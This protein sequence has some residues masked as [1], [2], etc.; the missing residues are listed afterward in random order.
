MFSIQQSKQLLVE[1]PDE[2]RLFSAL[3][4]HLNIRD[5]QVVG[6]GGYSGLRPFLRTFI[7]LPSFDMVQSVAIVADA[8]TNRTNREA[9]VHDAIA[10]VS[11]PTPSGP[12]QIASSSNIRVVYL[13]VPSSHP[14][15]MIEDVCLDS[16]DGDPALACVNDYF[17]CIEQSGLPGPKQ[18]WMSK[19]RVHAFLASRE[20][21]RLRLGEAA[22]RGVWQ[23]GASAFDP[24]KQLLTML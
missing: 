17:E 22:Q 18:V 6:Y 15:G 24:L 8:D 10:A 1:G 14:A 4:Q 19:A 9:G 16:V 3:L 21:P 11:W 7:S 20:D 13:V 5:V 2:E 12:L 23:F